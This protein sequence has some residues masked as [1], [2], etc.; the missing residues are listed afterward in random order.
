MSVDTDDQG[1][2]SLPAVARK[3]KTHPTTPWRWIR[4][5]VVLSDGRR[6]RLAAHKVGGTWRVTQQALDEFIAATTAASMPEDADF[7]DA[8]RSPREHDR[9]AARAGQELEAA[10]I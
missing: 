2:F 8:P 5:G 3:K 1:S 6:I 9:A 4:R 7:Y 10:G